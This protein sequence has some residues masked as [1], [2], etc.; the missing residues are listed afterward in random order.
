LERIGEAVERVLGATTTPEPVASTCARLAGE[1]GP[2][3][4]AVLAL[5]LIRPH[6]GGGLSVQWAV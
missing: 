3:G 2:R 5:I 4:A 1:P 6:R